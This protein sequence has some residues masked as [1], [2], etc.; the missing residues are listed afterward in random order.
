[1]G[2]EGKGREKGNKWKRW[3][4]DGTETKKVKKSQ[5]KCKIRKYSN[6][7]TGTR[8]NPFFSHSRKREKNREINGMISRF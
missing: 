7:L 8:L 6:Y 4:G 3:E 5:K 1:M 2:R